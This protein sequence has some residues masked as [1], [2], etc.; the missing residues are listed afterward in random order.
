MDKYLKEAPEFDLGKVKEYLPVN[1]PLLDYLVLDTEGPTG[2]KYPKLQ[3][4]RRFLEK[5]RLT[6]SVLDKV[7]VRRLDNRTTF[8]DQKNF[9]SEVISMDFEDIEASYYDFMR[10]TGKLYLR[11]HSHLDDRL[12]TGIQE[13]G[14]KQTSTTA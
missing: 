1:T 5:K 2:W 14:W 13:D 8:E 3:E 9:N 12:V 11:I 4:L 6:Y 10:I 7:E